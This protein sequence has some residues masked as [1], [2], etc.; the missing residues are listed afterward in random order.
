MKGTGLKE[1]R[2]HVSLGFPRKRSN[3]LARLGVKNRRLSRYGQAGFLSE[4][5]KFYTFR[6]SSAMRAAAGFDETKPILHGSPY[7]AGW[8]FERGDKIL[9]FSP[10]FGH[11]CGGGF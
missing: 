11:A 4:A 9:H 7:W 3:P 5:T 2:K 10:I 6:Q 1:D 8:V